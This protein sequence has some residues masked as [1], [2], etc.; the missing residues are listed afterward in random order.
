MILYRIVV[1]DV[2]GKMWESVP[3]DGYPQIS[4]VKEMI[5]FQ[6]KIRDDITYDE[7]IVHFNTDN[8]VSIVIYK[9]HKED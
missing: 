3:Q 1:F 8:V 7:A 4:R 9:I 5:N 2:T 6:I